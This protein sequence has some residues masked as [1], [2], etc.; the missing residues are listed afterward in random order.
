[1]NK[2]KMETSKKLLLVN[3]II[4]I[5][6]IIIIVIGSFLNYNMD[7]LTTVT[8]LVFVEVGASNAFYFRKAAKENVPK[9]L[10]GLSDDFKNKV[11]I[12]Q[13]LNS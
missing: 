8:G 6:L 7:G 3:Y 11:D 5:V 1:M 4:A 12:N 2:K 10:S 13:L 9:I